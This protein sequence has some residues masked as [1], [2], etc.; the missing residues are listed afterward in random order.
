MEVFIMEKEVYETPMVE[1]IRFERE[2]T[3][4]SP[5]PSNPK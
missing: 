1:V 5:H 2:I 3:T 4:S